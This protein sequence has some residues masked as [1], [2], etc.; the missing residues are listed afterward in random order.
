[1]NGHNTEKVYEYLRK[2]IAVIAGAML[3]LSVFLSNLYIAEEF[4]HDCCGEECPICSTIEECEAFISRVGTGLVVI[5]AAL[6]AAICFVK[7]VKVFTQ[8]LTFVTPV[9]EKVR[10]NN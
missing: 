3:F 4:V 2:S 9:S 10:L 5:A 8:E 7:S 6:F 1:M